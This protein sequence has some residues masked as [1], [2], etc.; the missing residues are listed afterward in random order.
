MK[1]ILFYG[2]SSLLASMW[3][4]LIEDK[5]KVFLTEHKHK[6]TNKDV[7]IIKVKKTNSENVKKILEENKI[8]V[9][10]NCVG[11]TNVEEC[12][13]NLS[14]SNYLNSNIPLILAQVTKELN[15]KLVHISTDH[16]FDGLKV[17]CKE[18]DIP[19]PLNYYAKSKLQGEKNVFSVNKNAL[20][21][22]T[23]FFGNGP[24]Y[25][26]S[27]SDLILNSLK[28]NIKISLFDD[29][30]YTPIVVNELVRIINILI[31]MNKSGIFNV[32]SNERITKYNFGVMIARKFNLPEELILKSKLKEREDLKRRPMDMSLSNLK[33]KT[34]LNM[35]I[36]SLA[37]Q[38]DKIKNK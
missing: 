17:F 38:L 37:K 35:E 6:I 5:S 15:V 29:V 23:N 22:R 32:V 28:L 16:L 25:R 36:S 34:K 18:T 19:K 30:Y 9:L 31:Q 14:N 20:V 4:K 27:F 13:L 8:D 21:I 3:C 11:L 10:V 33:I 1:N 2:G 12:E 26:K 24:S 7:N